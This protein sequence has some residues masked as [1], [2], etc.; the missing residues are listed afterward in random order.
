MLP[1]LQARHNASMSP[2]WTKAESVKLVGMLSGVDEVIEL[3]E[4]GLARIMTGGWDHVYSLSNDLASA[5]LA[6]IAAKKRRPVG[7]YVED[8][9]IQ[10]RQR[11][12]RALA[13]DGCLRPVE[14]AQHRILSASDE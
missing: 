11:G 2:G 9:I 13:R 6:S 4:P 12:R 3:A 8:G 1:A 10:P 7:Y 5:S 14:A